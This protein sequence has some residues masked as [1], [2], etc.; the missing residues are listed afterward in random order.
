[1]PV[2]AAAGAASL[3]AV[4][5]WLAATGAGAQPAAPEIARADGELTLFLAGDTIMPLPWSEDRDPDFLALV[6]EIRGADLA[7]VNLEVTLHA[8]RGHAQA[9]SGGG[10]LSGPPGIAHELAWAGVDMVST[11][12]NHSFDWGSIGV[13]ENID[14]LAKAGLLW[15]GTGRDLQSARAPAHFEHPDGKVALV[16]TASTF[17]PYGKASR[18]RPD[19]HGRPG[20]N[21]LTNE[22][23]R[24]VELPPFVARAVLGAAELVGVP[25]RR[26]DE[27]WFDLL[28]F[29]FRVGDGVA[30]SRG[31]R[32][33][34]ADLASNLATIK[35]AAAWAELV[36]FSIHAHHQ[37]PWLSELARRAIGAG[38]GV[39]FVHGP[40]EMRGIEIHAGA[41][42]FYSLGDFVFQPELSQRFP[43][44]SYE[45][46]GLD[47]NAT[48]DE[49]RSAR[50]EQ[51]RWAI[52]EP[53]E[54]VAA[55]ARFR[56]GT[57]R[58]IRL[59]PLDLGSGK[60]PGLRGKPRW[61]D[62]DMGRYLIGYIGEQSRPY[63]TEIRY[64]EGANVGLVELGPAPGSGLTSQL[65]QPG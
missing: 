36:V 64:V 9:D 49:L 51:G 13:V 23:R 20:L 40:H 29:R 54:S 58:E 53:F 18:S 32:V 8:Y 50:E 14:S 63:G 47:E 60:P 37:G 27:T 25:G 39:V 34:P 28:G 42:I 45:T 2:R 10:W 21:P 4:G 6:Q 38:A 41:P 48:P 1:L 55:V 65:D 26:L 17:T 56:A 22:P 33:D 30:V 62:P 3:L 59:L 15:A 11:A 31:R 44:E 19:V 7:V 52:R 35:A 61:A 43:A 5:L 57:L 24:H 12:N 46:H 16:A